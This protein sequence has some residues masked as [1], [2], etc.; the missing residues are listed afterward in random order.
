MWI[1]RCLTSR[2]ACALMALA[3][4]S[5]TASC[6]GSSGEAA[7]TTAIDSRTS[8]PVV[9]RSICGFTMNDGPSSDS[10]SASNAV[11]PLTGACAPLVQPVQFDSALLPF[12]HDGPLDAIPPMA[13][14][15]C[16][17][18][19]REAPI[20]LGL[21]AADILP[22]GP[23]SVGEL[24]ICSRLPKLLTNTGD[25]GGDLGAPAWSQGGKS[26]TLSAT[27]ACT[28]DLH[29]L[30]NPDAGF[31]PVLGPETISSASGFGIDIA[32]EI[33]DYV[34]GGPKTP[35]GKLAAGAGLLFVVVPTLGALSTAVPAAAPILL[36]VANVAV[37]KGV[38]LA[39]Q[40]AYELAQSG[41][42]T[43]AP[44]GQ[45]TAA[46][47]GGAAP[48]PQPTDQ[49]PTQ[50]PDPTDPKPTQGSKPDSDAE[51]SPDSCME[52]I[53][54]MLACLGQNGPCVDPELA[55]E[56]E[57]IR[58]RG[59]QM[60]KVL[61]NPDSAYCEERKPTETEIATVIV[62]LCL[63]VSQDRTP[64]PDEP[65]CPLMSFAGAGDLAQSI[66]DICTQ[67]LSES[68]N[69]PQMGDPNIP[70]RPRTLPPCPNPGPEACPPEQ[71]GPTN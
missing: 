54:R 10:P 34:W 51:R 38:S 41:Q 61:V 29:A 1:R 28:K 22:A 14:V 21:V 46:P 17:P 12:L 70:P 45:E 6:T 8:T 55:R 26:A 53:S 5:S 69:C 52:A 59:C 24:E 20:R 33:I 66:P 25:K 40:G 57:L 13:I 37:V 56:M 50:Q 23:R 2:L 58:L 47:G 64:A 27:E 4:M 15:G 68:F 16:M 44:A 60:D 3:L 7:P 31:G 42:Q 9:I 63:A 18:S 71:I 67:V 62:K 43:G 30:P 48:A 11:G 39:A 32:D 49:P 36:Q 19:Q 35:E 65:L